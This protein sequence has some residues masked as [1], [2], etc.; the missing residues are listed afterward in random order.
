M[1]L[2]PVFSQAYFRRINRKSLLICFLAALGYKT[3]HAQDKEKAPPILFAEGYFGSSTGRAPGLT[4]GAALNYQL[5][6]HFLTARY[7]ANTDLRL[8][9][10]AVGMVGF[11][12]IRERGNLEEFSFM[13]GRR[14][15]EQG[16]SFSLSMGLSYNT[17]TTKH[18]DPANQRFKT[19]SFYWGVPFEANVKWFK[20]SRERY[21][22]YGILPVGPPTGFGHSFGIKAFGNVSGRTFFGLGLVSGLGFH[23]RY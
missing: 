1:I 4:A 6:H 11:P 7:L 22:V 3:V 20:R 12:T 21:R 16:H 23:K 5:H 17:Y 18:L 13:Y 10:V 15:V 2:H 8:G 14:W 9:V 19:E